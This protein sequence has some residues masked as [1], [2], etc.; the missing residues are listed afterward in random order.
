MA[1]DDIRGT[2]PDMSKTAADYAEDVAGAVWKA[3]M[4][5]PQ[6]ENLGSLDEA[7]NVF[8]MGDNLDSN[9]M[10]FAQIAGSDLVTETIRNKRYDAVSV[11]DMKPSEGEIGEGWTTTNTHANEDRD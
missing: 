3:L 10:T 9:A 8:A 2:D 6:S 7:R 11:K 1:Y 5:R 4:N